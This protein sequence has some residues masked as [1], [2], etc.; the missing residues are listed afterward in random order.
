MKQTYT[1]KDYFEEKFNGIESQINHLTKM[2]EG[3]GKPGLM[4]RMEISES[5]W[6][7]LYAIWGVITGATFIFGIYVRGFIESI[8]QHIY[9]K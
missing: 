8:Y 1:D 3:N 2:I 9:G 6:T 7:R 5:R 4:Q